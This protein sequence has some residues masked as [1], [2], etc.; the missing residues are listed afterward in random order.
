MIR[1]TPWAAAQTYFRNAETI[2]HLRPD[3]V[4]P[5]PVGTIIA[6]QTWDIAANDTRGDAGPIFFM[7]K[8]P[9]GYDP[10]GGDWR[11]AMTRA[12]LTALADGKDGRATACR[13][14]HMTMKDRDYVP[15]IDR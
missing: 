9:A 14:C 4:T 7:K 3:L 6:M 13:T 12:D 11:Y 8:E 1:A 10:E 15:A 2:R 5:F